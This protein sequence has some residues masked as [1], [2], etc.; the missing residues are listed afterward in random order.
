MRLAITL[1]LMAVLRIHAATINIHES[2]KMAELFL[3][4]ADGNILSTNGSFF[5]GWRTNN[6]PSLTNKLVFTVTAP[7]YDSTGATGTTNRTIYGAFQRRETYPMQNTNSI[8]LEAGN[9]ILKTWVFL[10]DYIWSNDTVTATSLDGYYA[11]TNG[12]Q[13]TNASAFTGIT[14]TNSSLL[15]HA[16]HSEP[17]MN[18]FH[19]GGQRW[20][21]NTAWLYLRG[22]HW[23]GISAVEVIVHDGNSNTNRGFA[24]L[25]VAK[26]GIGPA[27]P[28]WVYEVDTSAMTNLAR[29]RCDFVAYPR[30]GNITFDTRSDRWVGSTPLPSSQT[31]FLDRNNQFVYCGVVDSAGSDANGCVTNVAPA[32][33]NSAHY[34]ATVDAV[35]NRLA[36]TN[37]HQFGLAEA[38]GTA[39]IRDGVTNLSGGSLSASNQ[40]RSWSIAKVY[41]GHSGII[42]TNTGDADVSEMFKCEGLTFRMGG[43]GN[44]ANGISRL[45]TDQCTFE[46][47]PSQLVITC[48]TWYVTD[49]TTIRMDQGFSGAGA[50]NTAVALLR[51][52]DLSGCNGTCI[53]YTAIGLTKRSTTNAS[54]KLST[55]KSSFGSPNPSHMVWFDSELLG[56]SNTGA[57]IEMGLN[58]DLHW[59]MW[60]ENMLFEGI[61][62]TGSFDTFSRN[63]STNVVFKNCLI[64][65]GRNQM[66]YNEVAGTHRVNC[67]S[68][69]NVTTV[70]G[71]VG[72][73]VAANAA[74]TNN[75]NFLYQVGSSG[76]V[77]RQIT[78]FSTHG[79]PNF[80]GLN[81]FMPVNGG[82]SATNFVQFVSFQAYHGSGTPKA[83]LGDYRLRNDSFGANDRPGT[84]PQYIFG[85]VPQYD[86]GGF[87]L[88]GHPRT[89]RSVAGPIGAGDNRKGAFF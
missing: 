75:H 70:T 27:R 38:I 10:S 46:A 13:F 50:Q 6:Q 12:P 68:I 61:V 63:D 53:P 25:S 16:L 59:G 67:R 22:G 3:T 8:F 19:P 76:N 40:T 72:D 32:S 31:N 28:Y 7:T 36:Q 34:F 74:Y 24:R 1:L 77:Y 2:G 57:N 21:N 73:V 87:D 23:S 42:T 4:S 26:P 18:W 80:H 85:N 20:T 52:T 82:S 44:I 9:T 88:Y 39:Y 14:V 43:N 69:N 49:C 79:W 65:G 78:G 45:W 83:G 11:V 71:F 60:I 33:V 51:D 58:V 41:P 86:L 84:L 17:S 55:D 66:F 37:F 5:G 81:S 89:K 48:P 35:W 30:I 47:T 64:L 56:M 29:I 62:S 15:T 54:F